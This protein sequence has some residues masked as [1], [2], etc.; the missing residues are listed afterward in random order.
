MRAAASHPDPAGVTPVEPGDAGE[1]LTLQR[2]AY[3]SE[4]STS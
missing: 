2:T 4:A 1:V 3:V